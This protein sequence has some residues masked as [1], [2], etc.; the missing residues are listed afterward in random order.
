MLT[1]N[2]ALLLMVIVVLRLRRRTQA[3]SRFDEK[4]TVLIVLALGIILAPTDVGQGIAGFL[5]QLVGS[6]SQ[7]GQ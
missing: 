6:V 7:A 5:G 2:V 4:M 1:I 3:R